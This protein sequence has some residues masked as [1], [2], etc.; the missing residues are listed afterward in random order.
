MRA[1]EDLI[2]LNEYIFGG[3]Q[4]KKKSL[5]ASAVG[6]AVA[7]T[8]NDYFSEGPKEKTLTVFW[9]KKKQGTCGKCYSTATCSKR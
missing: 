2:L 3:A 9:V 4:G 8:P 7:A 6:R 5:R 1:S